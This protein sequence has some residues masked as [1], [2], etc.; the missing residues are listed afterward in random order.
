MI[1]SSACVPASI[2]Y[3]VSSD[4]CL[5]RSSIGRSE[6]RHASFGRDESFARER[7]ECELF[8][9]WHDHLIPFPEPQ[10]TSRE[11]AETCLT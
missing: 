8:I 3:F 7:I 10:I 6:V 5:R 9:R 4:R 1:T 11:Q 2:L